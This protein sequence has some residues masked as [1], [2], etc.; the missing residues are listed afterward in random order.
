V[1]GTLVD[2]R[3]LVFLVWATRKRG[4]SRPVYYRPHYTKNQG[5]VRV[6][7]DAFLKRWE[8]GQTI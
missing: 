1:R 4:V 3:E 7:R 2:D 8:E 6:F 5:L